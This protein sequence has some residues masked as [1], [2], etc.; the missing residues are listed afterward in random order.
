MEDYLNEI[1]KS[2][3]AIKAAK[4]N[5][6]RTRRGLAKNYGGNVKKYRK[7]AGLTQQDLADSV[8]LSRPMI[9]AIERGD[10]IGS[11]DSFLMLSKI[12]NIDLNTLIGLT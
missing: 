9:I 8:G 3:A 1:R 7:K 5:I 4:E 6:K 10:H 2:Q 12:L 11:L